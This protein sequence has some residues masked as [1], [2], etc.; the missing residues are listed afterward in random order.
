MTMALGFVAIVLLAVFLVAY[1]A[2]PKRLVAIGLSAAR[3]LCG[4]RSRS[5]EVNGD[6]WHYLEGGPESAETLVL[7]HGFGADKDNWPLYGRALKKDYR[8]FIP[9]L[10]GFGQSTRRPDADYRI[11]AQTER[12]QS[13]IRAMGI[14]K[15]HIAGNSMGGC[16]A[17]NY[18]LT[19]P[20]HVHTVALLNKVR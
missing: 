5:I 9:D 18:A 8:V 17:L 3:R 2:F 12:L 7:L 19:Y 1:V 10:P 6:A 11:G 15:F 4:F 14:D 20:G 16:L 13:Y